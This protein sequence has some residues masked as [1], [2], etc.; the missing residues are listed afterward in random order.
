MKRLN[1]SA[2]KKG[3]ASLYVV[4][5]ATILFSVI[6]LSFVRI[7]LSETTQSANDELSQSAYDSALAGVEDAKIAVNKYYHCMDNP[8]QDGCN[9]YTNGSSTVDP[10]T[11]FNGDCEQ[12]KLKGLLYPNSYDT[13]VK[14]QES[15]SNNG[16]SNNNTDQAY[17]CVI[18]RNTVP[19]YRYTLTSDTRTRVVPLGIQSGK[20]NQ[21]AEVEFSWYSENN[22]TVFSNLD[23]NGLFNNKTSAPVP[24][25]VRLTLVSIHD[26]TAAYDDLP[27]D[28][29][30]YTMVLLPTEGGGT[31]TI[32]SNEILD[33]ANVEKENYPFQ[34]SCT[35]DTFACKVS[36][37][38][39]G[40]FYSGGSAFLMVSL[41]YGDT[42]SD[43]VVTLKDK[44]GNTI[45][46]ENVQISVDATGRANQLLR[47]VETRLDPSDIFFPYPE[48]EVTLGGN[49]DD[50]L[51]K[52]FW[53]TNNCWTEKGLCSNNGELSTSY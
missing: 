26:I 10:N 48:Y 35:H 17:T 22:G 6:T 9:L 37:S 38:T 3:A 36:L 33:T 52:N 24:P 51:K 23:H 15:N 29:N 45:D 40:L 34:I 5:F 50:S 47:R 27:G 46:F 31:N 41:P 20:L 21:V 16:D 43:F 49:G 32:S 19:D 14:I 12:F 1:L 42:V 2:T 13:E 28:Q 39:A 30:E 7:I 53:I 18:I 25:V 11:L 44:N 4:I 8:S